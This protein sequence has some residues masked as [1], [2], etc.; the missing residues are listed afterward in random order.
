MSTE[1][2]A[3]VEEY[4]SRVMK[5]LTR[6]A[7]ETRTDVAYLMGRVGLTETS[8]PSEVINAIMDGCDRK[9]DKLIIPRRYLK[10]E[11]ADEVRKLRNRVAHGGDET[12]G[13]EKIPLAT[14]IAERGF[15]ELLEDTMTAIEKVETGTKRAATE[16]RASRRNLKE[17][18]KKQNTPQHNRGISKKQTDTE[19]LEPCDRDS[20][21]EES[22]GTSSI[23]MV[24]IVAIVVALMMFMCNRGDSNDN[25]A[26]IPTEP[27]SQ[28]Q[29]TTVATTEE[30]MFNP[31]TQAGA[32]I[33]G[34]TTAPVRETNELPT[35]ITAEA[36]T[37]THEP[38]AQPTPEPEF[39]PF[40]DS[41]KDFSFLYPIEWTRLDINR[42]FHFK[43]PDGEG[44]LEVS[45][46]ASE[47]EWSLEEFVNKFEEANPKNWGITGEPWKEYQETKRLP[48]RDK[49]REFIEIHFIGQRASGGCLQQG[50]TRVSRSK[51]FGEF[52]IIGYAVTISGCEEEMEGL[53]E[54]K[55]ILL[56]SFKEHNHDWEIEKE[57]KRREKE[58]GTEET[59]SSTGDAE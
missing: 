49:E 48:G 47:R 50:I 3:Q 12:P 28:P 1:I 14:L 38:T 36:G 58:A 5:R 24:F 30:E 43:A 31:A 27:M 57:I 29:E 10:F 42:H 39:I 32:I 54:Q 45:S 33:G 17:D 55:E 21:T 34:P 37:T 46:M 22:S 11:E 53:G 44:R 18:E 15:E 6:F 19:G 41:S 40:T 35:P 23:A 13:G 7:H 56:N 8:N 25:T 9:R 2:E 26:P 20:T 16:A 59:P 4:T 51:Y 52:N